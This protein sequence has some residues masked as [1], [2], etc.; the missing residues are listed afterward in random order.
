M[1]ILIRRPWTT[2]H[3]GIDKK[4]NLI[5]LPIL[6]VLLVLCQVIRIRALEKRFEPQGTE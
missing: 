5:R 3:E 1:V 2:H 6:N 4:G